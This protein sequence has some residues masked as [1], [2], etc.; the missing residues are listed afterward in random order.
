MIPPLSSRPANGNGDQ[1]PGTG[2]GTTY[3]TKLYES[4]LI[5]SSYTVFD[6]SVHTKGKQLGQTCGKESVSSE[7]SKSRKIS[8][9]QST[10]FEKAALIQIPFRWCLVSES[11]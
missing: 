11:N 10:K 6:W 8:L 7:W 5:H 3:W 4:N 1:L 2:T 9:P